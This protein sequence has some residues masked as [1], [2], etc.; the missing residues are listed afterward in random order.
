M[1]WMAKNNL[2]R[3]YRSK[4]R[5][6]F[7]MWRTVVKEEIAFA[8]SVKNVIQKS[9]WKEGFARIKHQSR[10]I[11]FTQKVHRMLYRY[12]TKGQRIK[13]G[14]SFTK[15][16]KFA[17]AKVDDKTEEVIE[18]INNNRQAFQDFRDKASETNQVRITNYFI[19][20][21]TQ[22]IWRAWLKVIKHF[23][24]VKAKT[25]EFK[26]RQKKIRQKYAIRKWSMRM[27]YTIRFR[28]KCAL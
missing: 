20:K 15:W 13:M 17:F 12:S 14:D 25:A 18:A 16:K 27:S 2:T 28:T 4:K 11:D 24:L 6:I 7:E 26:A 9:M 22:N 19:E 3:V 21:N 5:M 1:E 10:D 8:H 23:K